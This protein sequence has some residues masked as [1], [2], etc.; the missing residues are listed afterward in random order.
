[1][2]RIPADETTLTT[3]MCE[4]MPI[5]ALEI[6]G[7]ANRLTESMW[8]AVVT[9]IFRMKSDHAR[10][11]FPPYV[12]QEGFVCSA[13]EKSVAEFK[14]LD[15]DGEVTLLEPSLEARRDHELWIA[16]DGTHLYEPISG[17][18]AKLREIAG[19][20]I[21]AAVEALQNGDDAGAKK[22]CR[23]ALCADD[24]LIEPLAISA[25]IARRQ[26]DKGT[27]HLM[28]KLAAKRTT[29]SGFEIMVKGYF[30]GVPAPV[31]QAA[32]DLL[33]LHSMSGIA[34]MKAA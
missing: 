25:A 1:M 3:A 14:H 5:N 13:T 29:P 21:A 26:N 7:Y 30:G 11:F 33:S 18:Q 12:I 4:P 17:A 6:I 9:P 24:R 15:E 31:A 16:E 28:A 32:P 19:K 20:N 8:P 10:V 23:T 34:A 2:Y 22:F 27:E